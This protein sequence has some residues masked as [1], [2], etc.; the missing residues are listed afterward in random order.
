MGLRGCIGEWHTGQR[1]GGHAVSGG[2]RPDGQ[3]SPLLLHA[4]LCLE[5]SE[6]EK[7][8]AVVVNAETND[9]IL[10]DYVSVIRRSKW[11]V[12]GEASGARK[13]LG[14]GPR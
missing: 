10:S 14:T 8:F 4:H 5:V 6:E 12:F 2:L 3:R 9:A 7:A 1:D 11:L 13:V